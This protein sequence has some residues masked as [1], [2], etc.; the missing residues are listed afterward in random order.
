VC[1]PVSPAPRSGYSADG[2]AVAG[3]RRACSWGGI[4]IGL[5]ALLAAG[6]ALV[7]SQARYV[8]YALALV[9]VILT[10]VDGAL[11]PTVRRNCAAA[12]LQRIRALD[13]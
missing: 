1:S 8:W 3:S 5:G 6:I 11:L 13:A 4:T 12:E 10:V 2:V 7:S 9:G